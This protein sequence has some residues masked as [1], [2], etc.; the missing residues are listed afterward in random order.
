MFLLILA[1][2]STGSDTVTNG[3]IVMIIIKDYPLHFTL[4]QIDIETLGS[5]CSA[6][7]NVLKMLRRSQAL[8][9]CFYFLL[10]SEDFEPFLKF[11]SFW[12]VLFYF[13]F[14]INRLPS[15]LLMS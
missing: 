15:C 5:E 10:F 12:T 7:K 4:K 13:Y 11:V 8:L 9:L 1:I 3:I 14:R 6:G 2:T